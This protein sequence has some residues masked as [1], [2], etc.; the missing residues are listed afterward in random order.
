M[1]TYSPREFKALSFHDAAPRFAGGADTPRAYL[2]RCLEAVAAR[3]PVVRAWAAL[4]EAGAREAADASA[5]RWRSG[6]PLSP[7]DGLPIGIQL[8]A[9]YAREDVLIRVA[10]QLEAAQPWADRRPPI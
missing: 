6:R 5:A 8:V 4:N 7:I 2:E 3:E 10:A 1:A 9:A